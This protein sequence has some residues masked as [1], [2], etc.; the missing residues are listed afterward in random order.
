MGLDFLWLC[1]ELCR[2][3]QIGFRVPVRI[4]VVNRDVR[5]G[6]RGLFEIFIDAAAAAL[7]TP[8]QLDRDARAALEL[9]QFLTGLSIR[10]RRIVGY[11][12]DA[13]IRDSLV[14]L[15][16]GRNLFALAAAVDDLRLVPLRVD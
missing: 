8:F 2:R 5:V 11:P 4:D 7:I 6:D 14:S 12:F 13:A 10:R 1:G 16:A 9:L 15:L 3:P